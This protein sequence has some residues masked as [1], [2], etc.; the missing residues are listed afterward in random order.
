MWQA[1]FFLFWL[2]TFRREGKKRRWW[3]TCFKTIITLVRKTLPCHWTFCTN[4]TPGSVLFLTYGFPCS[5]LCL[6]SIIVMRLSAISLVLWV[7]PVLSCF[8]DCKTG[9][10]EIWVTHKRHIKVSLPGVLIEHL[11]TW[12]PAWFCRMFF[13]LFILNILISWVKSTTVYFLSFGWLCMCSTI[14]IKIKLNVEN[15]N[16][17]SDVRRV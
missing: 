17:C 3:G 4:S 15:E 11:I 1:T 5:L 16:A 12:I 14:K 7:S 2:I 10:W 13:N 6:A 9:Y 8:Y